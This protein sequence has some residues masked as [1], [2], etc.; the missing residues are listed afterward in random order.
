[1]KT[2]GARGAVAEPGPASRRPQHSP[3][4]SIQVDDCPG[5]A[6]MVPGH[7]AGQSATFGDLY[8]GRVGITP[9]FRLDQ[10]ELRTVLGTQL[11]CGGLVLHAAGQRITRSECSRP[12]TSGGPTLGAGSSSRLV[13]YPPC[14][15][16]SHCLCRWSHGGREPGSGDHRSPAHQAIGEQALCLPAPARIRGCRCCNDRYC[17]GGD[18][19]VLGTVADRTPDGLDDPYTQTSCRELRAVGGPPSRSADGG[20]VVDPLLVATPCRTCCIPAE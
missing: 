10:A 4:G 14:H 2:S 8:R 1:M 11:P 3:L 5:L 20:L 13:I 18:A 19:C 15:E 7:G 6:D 17:A 16:C 9:G 12:S